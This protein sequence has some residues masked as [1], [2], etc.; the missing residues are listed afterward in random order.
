M[1]N[2]FK[3]SSLL[4]T[5]WLYCVSGTPTPALFNC[6][7]SMGDHYLQFS[8]PLASVEDLSRV[9]TPGGSPSPRPKMRHPA[10]SDPNWEPPEG[11]SYNGHSTGKSLELTPLH[12]K[13]KEEEAEEKPIFE[14]PPDK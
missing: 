14:G 4:G 5:D 10:L 9:N 2:Y 12:P 1:R 11:A 6:M 7:G 8:A 13:S 3:L